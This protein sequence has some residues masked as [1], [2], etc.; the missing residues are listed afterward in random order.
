MTTSL[1]EFDVLRKRGLFQVVIFF[2][3][4]FSVYAQWYLIPFPNYFLFFDY[5]ISI[6]YGTVLPYRQVSL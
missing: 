6:V 2:R 3:V 4:L 1:G 5:G